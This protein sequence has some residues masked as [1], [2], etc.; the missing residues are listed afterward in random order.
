MN[1]EAEK[2]HIFIFTNKHVDR[3]LPP[4]PPRNS[5]DINFQMAPD[6]FEFSTLKCIFVPIFILSLT[7]NNKDK[8]WL[9][10]SGLF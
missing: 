1:I 7:W 10:A 4:P 3:K 9:S 6:Q 5:S 8:I 2:F